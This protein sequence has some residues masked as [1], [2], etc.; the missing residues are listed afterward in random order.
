[1]IARTLRRRIALQTTDAA[2]DRALQYLLCDPEIPGRAAQD[3]VI[4][5]E[6][7]GDHYLILEPDQS[8]RRRHTPED[9]VDCLHQRLFDLSVTD[10]PSAPILHAASLRAHDRRLLLVG[11]KGTGKTTLTL[12][13]VRAGYEVE[14][15]ENVFIGRDGVIVRPR[16]LRV[17][18]ASLPLIPEIAPIIARAPRFLDYRRQAIYNIDPRR[19]GASWRIEEGR[20]DVVILLRANHGG[21]SSIRQLPPLEVVQELMGEIGLPPTGRGAAVAAIA[22]V[23][24]QARGFD[25]SLGDHVSA[26]RCIDRAMAGAS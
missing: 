14:G 18:E 5:V 11:S 20:V 22:A 6:A 24:S 7:R 8:E 3:F 1:V 9:V 10:G 21:T 17:K 13:L 16:G 15:D 23:F 19:I 12:R 26:I 2:V 4:T 25:L